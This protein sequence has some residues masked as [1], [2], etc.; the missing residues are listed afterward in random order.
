M[1]S[2]LGKQTIAIYILQNISRS[3]GNQ[4]IRFVQLIEY[5]MRNIFHKKSYAKCGG[6]T[7]PGRFPK[8][9]EL[10][11][12]NIQLIVNAVNN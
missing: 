4:T 6:E 7:I 5:E 2:Q 11:I 9:L 1:T 3:K 10:S 8:K 12:V